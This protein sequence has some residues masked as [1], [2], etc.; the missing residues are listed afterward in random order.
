[1]MQQME[2]V[3][4][5]IKHFVLDQHFYSASSLKNSLQIDMSFHS[6]TFLWFRANQSLLLLQTY[7]N[8]PDHRTWQVKIKPVRRCYR[9]IGPKVSSRMPIYVWD[10]LYFFKGS[11]PIRITQWSS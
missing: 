10:E 8:M 7:R 9:H 11:Y 4:I 2:K 6:D 5:L 3:H 1:M